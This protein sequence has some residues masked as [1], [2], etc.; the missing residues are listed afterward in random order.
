MSQRWKT[1]YLP[2]GL[3]LVVGGL[4]LIHPQLAAQ[5]FQSGVSLC[6]RTV[7]PALFPF[8]VLCDLLLACP[9]Q[10]RFLGV[11]AR[12]WGMQEKTCAAAVL[13][14][15]FGGYAVCAQLAGRLRR[16]GDLTEREATLLMMLGCCSSPGFVIS[17]IGGLLFGNLQLGILLYGLQLAANLLSTALC[18]F[19]VPR[20]TSGQ[21]ATHHEQRLPNLPQAI[22]NAVSSS[23]QVCGCVIFFRILSAIL[24]PYLPGSAWTAPFLS[25]ILEISSGCAD[26]AAI[27]GR[28]GL[29]GCCACLSLLGLSVWAQIAL[30]LQGVVQLRLLVLQRS[31]HLVCFLL[32]IRISVPF[33]PG[34]D[35]VYSTL[36]D[37]VIPTQRLPLDAAIVGFVFLCAALYKVRQSFYNK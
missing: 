11:L 22:S 20:S 33:L 36:A 34:V 5:G 1:T 2:V 6:I 31:I 17:C 26:F 9:L 21:K 18:L 14:S 24:L 32:M 37:R 16:D 15:W 13:L 23:L 28:T 4:L 7:L 10:G 12:L 19:L 35:K 3:C 25:A 8:F 29:Y 30:L 27:G